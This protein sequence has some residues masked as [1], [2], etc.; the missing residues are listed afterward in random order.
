M[1]QVN[2]G[3]TTIWERWNSLLPD[4]KISGTMM[5]S[6]NHYAYGSVAEA[7]YQWVGGLKML[8]TAWKKARIAPVP[9]H[10]VYGCC[11]EYESPYGCYRVDWQV[12]HH[13]EISL[14]VR[15]PHGC[16]AEIC[17][18]FSDRA[19]FEVGEGEH[20]FDYVLKKDIRHPYSVDNKVLDLLENEQVKEAFAQKLPQAYAMATSE[21]QEF[22]VMSV[23]EMGYLP[24]FGTK[25][26]KIAELDA[27]LKK[28]GG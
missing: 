23:R 28:I 14:K 27:V 17:L 10:R 12:N 1:Y 21:N 6:L 5:N 26:E 13:N 18:P 11:I 19:P 9:D 24:M 15:I 20:S 8:D 3:A 25:A 22:L 16:E 7:I 2:L 4:G